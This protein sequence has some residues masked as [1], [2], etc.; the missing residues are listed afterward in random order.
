MV[1]LAQLLFVLCLSW[2]PPCP[3][4]FPL[5]YA[6]FCATVDI[7]PQ[8]GT[9]NQFIFVGCPHIKQGHGSY[10]F[11]L[12]CASPSPTFSPRSLLKNCKKNIIKWYF[13]FNF[14][15]SQASDLIKQQFFPF[16]KL[17]LVSLKDVVLL[18]TSNIKELSSLL[19]KSHKIYF[20]ISVLMILEPFGVVMFLFVSI[21]LKLH[22][23]INCY[24]IQSLR[25]RPRHVKKSNSGRF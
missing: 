3:P 20:K 7:L 4:L 24:L 2:L 16:L 21:F 17:L 23:K 9:I 15:V 19:L 13:Y 10:P 1:M 14:L 8:S 25:P 12:S 11:Q 22:Q 5:F 6:K 18:Q